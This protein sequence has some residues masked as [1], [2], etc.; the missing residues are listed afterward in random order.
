MLGK[1]MR[2]KVQKGTDTGDLLLNLLWKLNIDKHVV[3]KIYFR[4]LWE[5]TQRI[6]KP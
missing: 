1:D 3:G 4:D 6:I 5:Y 2:I